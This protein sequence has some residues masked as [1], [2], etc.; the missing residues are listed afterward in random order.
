MELVGKAFHKR[1]RHVLHMFV[2][3]R[4]QI[5]VHPSNERNNKEEKEEER[6]YVSLPALGREHNFQFVHNRL[7]RLWSW[8]NARQN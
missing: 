5:R 2:P 6:I 1:I 7:I 8:G 3:A 4:E